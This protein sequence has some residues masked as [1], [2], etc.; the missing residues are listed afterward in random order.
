MPIYIALPR[1]E[2]LGKIL[3]RNC[4]AQS[5]AILL[6]ADP[7]VFREWDFAATSLDLVDGIRQVYPFLTCP[8][9]HSYLPFL[10]PCVWVV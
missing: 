6:E 2:V 7:A 5:Y 4:W 3:L 1:R 8:C 9:K 10:G